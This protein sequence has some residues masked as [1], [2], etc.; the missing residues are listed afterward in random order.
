MRHRRHSARQGQPLVPNRQD[1][2]K[3][4]ASTP[5]PLTTGIFVSKILIIVDML[6]DF[7]KP[8]GKLYFEKGQTVVEPIVRLKTAFRATG[9][10]VLY[11]NDAHPENSEEFSHWPPHCLVGTWG[12]RI[13]EELPP[14]PDDIIL[15]KD[16]L[17][18]FDNALAE[19]MLQGLGVSHLY[20]VGVATE[21]CVKGCALDALTRGFAVTV[22]EDAI[23][24][25]DLKA[26]DAAKALEAMRLAGALFAN[27]ETII[28]DLG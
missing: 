27:T 16:S 7:I 13:V 5:H 24:G 4:T 6:N 9:L 12:A 28:T 19:N 23:A 15:H 25:V 8:D 1:V 3:K 14:G 18:L 26:G 21:Y 2:P 20:L 11:G 22:I 10:P 17:R